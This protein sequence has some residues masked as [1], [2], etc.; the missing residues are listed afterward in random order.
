[1]GKLWLLRLTITSLRIGLFGLV[2]WM[3]PTPWNLATT[4][5]VWILKA[6][7]IPLALTLKSSVLFGRL[8]S[9]LRSNTSSRGWIWM[10]FPQRSI[11]WKEKLG[12]IIYAQYVIVNLKMPYI[13]SLSVSWQ[14]LSGLRV[15]FNA[16]MTS[17]YLLTFRIGLKLNCLFHLRLGWIVS[18]LL[19]ISLIYYE[20]FGW[21]EINSYPKTSSGSYKRNQLCKRQRIYVHTGF[22]SSTLIQQS[23]ASL[24]L[25]SW[26]WG[27]SI[28]NGS[29]NGYLPW[30]V[31]C[32]LQN[33]LQGIKRG[34]LCV[35]LPLGYFLM[36]AR[37]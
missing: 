23:C 34:M 6:L 37:N 35:D 9:N 5:L 13:S 16:V 17:P 10:S 19:K 28:V 31:K 27:S 7:Q 32:A 26:S 14:R 33:N 11:Y 24:L 18:F 15:C 12:T 8:R 22:W 36:C 21:T 29:S 1:M 25:F 3:D 4:L 30:C 2:L 20:R